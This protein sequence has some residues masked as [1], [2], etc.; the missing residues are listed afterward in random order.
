MK[1]TD[2][3]VKL[4]EDPEFRQAQSDLHTAFMLGDSVLRARLEKGWSQSE[5][6]RKI[7][8]K[9]ANISRLEAGLANPT[10][11]FLQDLC[12]ELDLEILIQPRPSKT[13][14]YFTQ[15]IDPANVHQVAEEK[16]DQGE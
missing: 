8:T 5:L 12:V 11:R 7:G 2:Y 1:Y 14:I 16:P 13:G 6:A 4:A 10:L 3:R 15:K 9:Q